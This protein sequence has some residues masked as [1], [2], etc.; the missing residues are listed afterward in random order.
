MDY[1]TIHE[2]TA[3]ILTY[4]LHI[5]TFK[6]ITFKAKS[7]SMSGKRTENTISED[8]KDNKRWNGLKPVNEYATFQTFGLIL[9]YFFVLN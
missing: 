2:Y 8:D 9:F 6:F 1:N 3:I 7:F 5:I 4:I